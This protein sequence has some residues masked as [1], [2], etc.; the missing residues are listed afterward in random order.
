MDRRKLIS[1]AFSEPPQTAAATAA[2]NH[3]IRQINGL[4]TTTANRRNRSKVM[5]WPLAVVD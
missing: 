1:L 3:R 5:L 2:L 4:R